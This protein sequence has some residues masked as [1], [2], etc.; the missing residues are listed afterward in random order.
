MTASKRISAALKRTL[1]LAIVPVLA[2]AQPASAQR[3]NPPVPD[4]ETLSDERAIELCNEYAAHP[5][6]PM[7]PDDVPGVWS[8]RDVAHPAASVSCN[9]AFAADQDNPRMWF[10]WARVSYAQLGNRSGQPRHIMKIAYRRGSEIAGIYLAQM[11]PEREI[12]LDA[13]IAQ[14]EAMKG[15][16]GAA[17][18]PRPMTSR[19]RDELLFG[20]LIAIGSIALIRILTGEAGAPSGECSGGYMLSPVTHEIYCNGLVVGSY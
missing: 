2:S 9:R 3:V 6:D 16:Q 14:M 17:S 1:G 10:Q 15:R 11:P 20:S 19:E 8:D 7:K 18:G 12:D 13:M 4:Y 5:M